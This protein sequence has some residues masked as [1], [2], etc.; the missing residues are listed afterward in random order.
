MLAMEK[1]LAMYVLR[2]KAVEWREVFFMKNIA[3]DMG[4]E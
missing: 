2:S 1:D 4:N 3:G